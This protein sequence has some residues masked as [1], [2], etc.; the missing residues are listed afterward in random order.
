MALSATPH[1][2]S[3]GMRTSAAMDT[4]SVCVSKPAGG[5]FAD[6]PRQRRGQS[7][8]SGTLCSL[9]R[10]LRPMLCIS[11]VG[12]VS[13]HLAS[14]RWT[15]HRRA[16]CGSGSPGE[17][18]EAVLAMARSGTFRPLEGTKTRLAQWVGPVRSIGSRNS[19]VRM[20]AVRCSRSLSVCFTARTQLMPCA[21]S[22]CLRG[23][24]LAVGRY[25]PPS[26][27][28]PSCRGRWTVPHTRPR[29]TLCR[30]AAVPWQGV[31]LPDP[32]RWLKA[33]LRQDLTAATSLWSA[34]DSHGFP[35][36]IAE[37]P[38]PLVRVLSYGPTEELFDSA[39][40]RR[41]LGVS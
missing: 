9:E 20:R 24:R 25:A 35:A 36:A 39:Q 5:A 26:R 6:R 7:L 1:P 8:R 27:A 18:E 30:K 15:Y 34:G 10:R 28:A 11:G 40:G 3:C 19:T 12:R 17:S 29:A 33:P 2:H 21:V 16:P 23:R 13:P 41:G 22:G 38:S 31:G 4:P 37:L 14:E 32:N